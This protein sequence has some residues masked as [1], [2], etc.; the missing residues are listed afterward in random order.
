MASKGPPPAMNPWE[1]RAL[2][3]EFPNHHRQQHD[4]KIV[5]STTWRQVQDPV[6]YP[7]LYSATGFDIM[8]ILLQ[9]MS[10]PYPKIELGPVDCS[11]AVIVCDLQQADCPIVYASESFCELT[12]YGMNEVLGRN[13]RFL[14]T[15]PGKMANAADAIKSVDR[16]AIH[17]M[18]QAVQ[19]RSELQLNVTNYKKNGE[20]FTNALSII[21][22]MPQGSDY[23]YAVGFQV[24][25]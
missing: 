14:Q 18:R 5:T 4:G 22:V 24:E 15:P 11:V 12:G 16:A 9:V 7:G 3:Y 1:V 20:R 10:R 2:E 6:I 21:P 17:R 8:S 23:R 25:L 13:C 19:T